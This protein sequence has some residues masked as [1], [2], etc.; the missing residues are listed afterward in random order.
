MISSKVF[1]CRRDDQF[2]TM[3]IV[4]IL[5]E[6]NQAN[7]GVPYWIIREIS[8]LKELDHINIV[9]LLTLLPCA[10]SDSFFENFIF[11]E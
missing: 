6:E 1:K 2:F 10:P 3:K 9:R 5:N 8:I 7:N 11:S 4:S